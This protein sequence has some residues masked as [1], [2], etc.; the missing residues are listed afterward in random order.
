VSADEAFDA[1]ASALLGEPG[2]QDGT[3]FGRNSGLRVNAK[4]FTFVKDGA[5]VVKLSAERCAAIAAAG[6][7]Q[8]FMTGGRPLREWVAVGAGRVGEWPA[9]ASEAM[10]FVRATR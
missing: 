2:V 10:E 4:I 3:G 9:L 5:L 8:P 7:A 1:I 6:D